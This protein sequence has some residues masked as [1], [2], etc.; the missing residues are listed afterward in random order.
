M[1]EQRDDALVPGL[2]RRA[3]TMEEYY[4]YA[5]EK[6]ELIG[7]YLFYGPDVPEHRLRLL[8]LLL[9]NVGLLDAVKLVPEERWRAALERVYGSGE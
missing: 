9:G 8:R 3:I 1:E 6:F 4:G 5:P 2:E 7:G